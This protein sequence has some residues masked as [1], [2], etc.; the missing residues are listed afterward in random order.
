MSKFAAI[1]TAVAVAFAVTGCGKK[2]EAEKQEED[3]QKLRDKKRDNAI[4]YYK[5]LS[6]KFPDSEHAAEAAQRAKALEATKEKK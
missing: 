3:R 6:E 1:L 5:T 4:Q 2:S